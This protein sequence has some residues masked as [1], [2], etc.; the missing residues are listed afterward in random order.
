L[1]AIRIGV[2][3]GLAYRSVDGFRVYGDGGTGLIDWVHP[4]TPRRQML[5]PDAHVL[6]GHL[7]GGHLMGPHLDGVR[8]DGHLEGTHLLDEHLFPAATMVY[9]T[10]SFVFGRFRHAVVT[11]DDLG[12]A[13]VSGVTVHETVINSDPPPAREFK[14][15]AYDE[16]SDQMSFSFAPSEQLTG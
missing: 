10:D 12:N 2:V 1:Q 4:V 8:P 3:R 16:D 5:W 11:E 14:A 6:P 9:E 13:M 7:L 15:A